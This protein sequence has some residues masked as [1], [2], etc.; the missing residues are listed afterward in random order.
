MLKWGNLDAMVMRI[1]YLTA[2]LLS[3]NSFA[4]EKTVTGTIDRILTD[5]N[6]YGGC[7][8]LLRPENSLLSF[9]L[10]CPSN[11]ITFDCRGSAGQS[12][13]RA[14]AELNLQQSQ[15]AMAL[16]ARVALRVTDSVKV[17]GHCYSPRV[18]VFSLDQ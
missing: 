9:G 17:N 5:G 1:F 3:S 11:Y 12:G 18:E 13:G 14:Q 6:L 7:M 15:L 2:L 10:D 16:G 8:V 4:L